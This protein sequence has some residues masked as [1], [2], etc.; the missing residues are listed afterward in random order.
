VRRALLIP[1]IAPTGWAVTWNGDLIDSMTDASG[2][3]RWTPQCAE[4][5][6]VN[7]QRLEWA[8][9]HPTGRSVPPS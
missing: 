7:V 2:A 4:S 8:W 3:D 1:L 9:R 6:R 5:L